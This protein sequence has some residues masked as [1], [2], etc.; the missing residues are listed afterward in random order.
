MVLRRVL[1]RLYA[2]KTVFYVMFPQGALHI[3]IY[4]INGCAGKLSTVVI[5]LLY[6]ELYKDRLKDY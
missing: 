5:L 1:I 4:N 6:K 3:T 2:L